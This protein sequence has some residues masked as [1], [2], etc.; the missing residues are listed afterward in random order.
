M[1][2]CPNCHRKLISHISARCNWCGHEINDPSYQAEARVQREA[3]FVEQAVHDAQS[4]IWSQQNNVSNGF[5]PWGIGPIRGGFMPP[6]TDPRI[7][8]M[9]VRRAALE[10]EARRIRSDRAE[11]FSN[12]TSDAASEPNAA[13]TP[14]DAPAEPSAEGTVNDDRFRHLEL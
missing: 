11:M 13:N 10:A 9:A 2:T 8:M 3:F 1:D 7:E 14:T 5:D 4:L 12:S 6:P